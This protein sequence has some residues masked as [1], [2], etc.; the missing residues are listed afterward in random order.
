MESAGGIQHYNIESVVLGVLYA[1]FRDPDGVGLSHLENVGA[2]LFADD[3]Q[4]VDSGRSV[5]V[6]GNQQRTAVLRDEV[7]CKLRAVGGL[8]GTL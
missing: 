5:D 2:C 1:L 6:A 8:T 4:L 3:L 7:L